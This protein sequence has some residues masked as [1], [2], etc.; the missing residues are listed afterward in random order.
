[1]TRSVVRAYL[2][3]LAAG[4]ALHVAPG[5][6][7][8][9]EET[10]MALPALTIGFAP[11]YIADAQG[12]WTKRGLK[13]TL[14]DITGIG[15]M[16]AML[17]GSVDFSNSSGPTVIR[18][19]VRG[20]KV[21]ALGSTYDGLP[22]ELVVSRKFA[23]AAG[24]DEKAPLEKRMRALRGK[25]VSLNTP[26]SIPHAYL[27]YL[28]HKAGLNP[29]R[30]VTVVYLL[31]EAGIAALKAGTAEGYIQAPPWP[32]IAIKQAGGVRLASALRGDLPELLPF[33]F[34]IVVTRPDVCEKRASVCQKLM[35]G[36][37]EGMQFMRER[38]KESLAILS[39][40]M[41]KVD[42]AVLAE[43]FEL[44]A[45][46]TPRSTRID[47]KALQNAQQLMLVGGMLKADEKLASFE[48]IYTNRFAK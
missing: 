41:P 8:K 38:P 33:P 30:D 13:V 45:A 11:T 42:A 25:R 24:V 27:R 19:N 6:A 32:M 21:L 5:A 10:T 47:P 46:G 26:N 36:Y 7:Q 3:C 16:N 9:P 31:P 1:M 23:D 48:A 40:K 12:F 35:E 37:L 43:S 15:S 20:Q 4:A 44:I 14:H 22:F 17:A 2:A 34:N 28:L 29:E 18:A 39:R